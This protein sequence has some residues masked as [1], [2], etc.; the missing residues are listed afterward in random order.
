[1]RRTTSPTTT[2]M[3]TRITIA[4][5]L[6]AI[7]LLGSAATALGEASGQ[8]LYGPADDKVVTNAGFIII[9]TVPLFVGLMSALQ[10]KL[11]KRKNARK[12][13]EKARRTRAEW[14]GG[15]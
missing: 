10:W 5:S 9:I 7:A 14:A 13:A 8:G 15:W 12:A 4:L 11:D 1:M 6:V 3:A 2:R